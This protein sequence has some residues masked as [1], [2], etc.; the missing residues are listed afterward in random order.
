[1]IEKTFPLG[2]VVNIGEEQALVVGY[3]FIEKDNHMQRC[4]IVVPYPNGYE[5]SSSLKIAIEEDVELLIEGFNSKSSKYVTDY[6]NQINNLA[7]NITAEDFK[8]EWKKIQE[9]LSVGEK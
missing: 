3:S 7:K 6:F 4:Y 5:N 2:T 1:M 8:K 9:N